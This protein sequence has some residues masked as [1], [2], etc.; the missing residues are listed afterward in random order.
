MK[1]RGQAE[2]EG[3][4]MMMLVVEVLRAKNGLHQMC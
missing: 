4:G 1:R 3:E 2:M